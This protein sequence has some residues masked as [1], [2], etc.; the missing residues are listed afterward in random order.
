MAAISSAKASTTRD[1]GKASAE[2]RFGEAVFVG[3]KHKEGI[4]GFHAVFQLRSNQYIFH[5]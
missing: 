5:S 3:E 2:P 4:L 1:L